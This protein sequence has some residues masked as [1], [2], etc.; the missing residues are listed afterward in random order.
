MLFVV[1]DL[2]LLVVVVIVG[3]VVVVVVCHCLLLFVNAVGCCSASFEAD[4]LR[5]VVYC[6]L[7]LF[8]V[9]G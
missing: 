5:Y 6:C 3:C 9:V 2:G 8:V 7:P 1:C 4:C